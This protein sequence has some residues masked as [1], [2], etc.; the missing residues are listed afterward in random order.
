MRINKKTVVVTAV[1]LAIAGALAAGAWVSQTFSASGTGATATPRPLTGAVS[2]VPTD[3]GPG[4][5][6]TLTVTASNPNRFPVHVNNATFAITSIPGCPTDSFSFS[7]PTYPHRDVPAATDTDH[8][9]TVADAAQVTL[10]FVNTGGNQNACLDKPVT[11]TAT[12][13]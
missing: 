12:V 11:V 5:T 10:T 8:P 13:S 9:G 3:F 4:Q 2:G 1:P 7:D 6:A